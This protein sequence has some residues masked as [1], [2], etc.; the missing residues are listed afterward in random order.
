MGNATVAVTTPTA[1]SDPDLLGLVARGQVPA[2]RELY[3]RHGGSLLALARV[4]AR[5]HR[6]RID[7][8]QLVVDVF[9]TVWRSPPSVDGPDAVKGHLV[10]VLGRLAHGTTWTFA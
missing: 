2:L 1:P 7:P 6:S 10:R 3:D 9:V 8:E 4:T 5:H